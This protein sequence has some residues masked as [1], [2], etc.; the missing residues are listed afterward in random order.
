VI[1]IMMSTIQAERVFYSIP[2]KIGYYDS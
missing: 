1:Y 2:H